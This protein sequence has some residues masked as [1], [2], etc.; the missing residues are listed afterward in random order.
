MRCPDRVEPQGI[1]VLRAFSIGLALAAVFA[2]AANGAPRVPDHPPAAVVSDTIIL[3]NPKA[4]VRMDE[5]ASLSCPHCA[6]FNKEV[7]P[8][9]KAKYID[10][11]K[12]AYVL[13]EFITPPEQVAVAGFM[14][15]R[16]A[17]PSKYYAG[18]DDLFHRQAKIYETHDLKGPIVEAGKAV[19]MNEDAVAACLQNQ[20]A[21]DALTARVQA[22]VD[23]GIS[24]TPTFL[25]NGVKV[26]EGE[27]NLQE[28]D[29]AYAAALKP[30]PRKTK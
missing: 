25:F 17:A 15:A 13:H 3:G 9:F 29:A 24:S 11:G 2:L 20:K 27:M 14:L 8:A 10:T 7:F 18:V 23:A 19:G 1:P 28:L 6:Q 30:K 5:Y 12:V 16:C 26:K 22:G 21:L 4:R